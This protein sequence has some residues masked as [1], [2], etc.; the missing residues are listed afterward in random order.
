MIKAVLKKQFHDKA[1]AKNQSGMIC[2]GEQTIFLYK[3]SLKDKPTI[4]NIIASLAQNNNGTLQLSPDGLVFKDAV[5]EKDFAFVEKRYV[6]D[7]RLKGYKLYLNNISSRD[8][9]SL[10]NLT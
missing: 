6:K 10:W 3:I 9:V 1:A 4:Q 7:N 5:P 2:S 8:N